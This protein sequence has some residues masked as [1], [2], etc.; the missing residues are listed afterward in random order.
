MTEKNCLR[1]AFL[2]FFCVTATHSMDINP[3]KD[4][5]LKTNTRTFHFR[6]VD[7]RNLSENDRKL[8]LPNTADFDA[9]EQMLGTIPA[10][11]F[12]PLLYLFP[13]LAYDLIIQQRNESA[14]HANNSI[15]ADWF[16]EENGNF[17]GH[18]GLTAISPDVP[19]AIANKAL[20]ERK[21]TLN[22]AG[23]IIKEY[24]GQGCAAELAPLFISKLAEF[25]DFS[26][27]T[28]LVITRTDNG[29]INRICNKLQLSSLGSETVS[30]NLGLFEMKIDMNFFATRIF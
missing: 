30:W 17:V 21:N 16:I 12:T 20:N 9:I 4:F 27:K 13:S 14:L 3:P 6:E 29:P 11:I 22:I 2:I 24:R 5:D 1:S 18:V 23:S 25:R 28:V 15:M 10:C 7:Y 8:Y 26:T 19:D